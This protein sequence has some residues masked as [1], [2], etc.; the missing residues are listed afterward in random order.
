MRAPREIVWLPNP[1]RGTQISAGFDGSDTDDYTALRCRTRNGRLFTPRYG[2]DR[3]P[4]IWRPEEWGGQVPRDQIDVAVAEMFDRWQVSRMYCDPFG[5][6]SEVGRWSATYG[7]RRV[8]EWATNRRKPMFEAIKRFETDLRTGALTQDGCPLTAQAVANARKVPLPGQ[9]YGLGKPHGEYHRKID[10]AIASILAHEAGS[11]AT[12]DSS[13][14][15]TPREQIST[16]MYG[17]N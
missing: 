8:V 4:T 12:A 16:V 3:R 9:M 2:P 15:E 14:D 17:F 1:P 10:A 11:D 5:Y 13:W 7:E 6:Y